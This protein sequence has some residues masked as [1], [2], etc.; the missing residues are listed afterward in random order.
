MEGG[1]HHSAAVAH[2]GVALALDLARFV[3]EHPV[4]GRSVA[5]DHCRIAQAHTPRDWVRNWVDWS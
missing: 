4:N 2:L 3:G 1:S 5:Y